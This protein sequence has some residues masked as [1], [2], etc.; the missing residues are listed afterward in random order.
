MGGGEMN[1]FVFTTNPVARFKR[2]KPLLS[3]VSLLDKVRVAYREL[4]SD[5]FTVLGPKA[6]PKI[7]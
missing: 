1:I 6:R 5:D 4:L 2:A 3:D 7:S